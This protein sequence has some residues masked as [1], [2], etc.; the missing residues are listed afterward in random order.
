VSLEADGRPLAGRSTQ[1]RRLALLTLLAVARERGMTRDKVLAFLWP[2]RDPESAR[3]SLSQTLYAIH[4]ELGHEA[5][6]V[7][8][9]DLRL[10]ASVVT[11]DVG[12]FEEALAA[13]RRED[14][15]RVYGGAFLDG[16]FVSDAPEFERWA[17]CERQRLAAAYRAALAALAEEAGSRGEHVRAVAWWRK[18]AALEP[19]NSHIAVRLM[20]ALARTG[21]RAGAIQHAGA[22]AA[23]L[24][25]ELDAGADPDV[26][27]LAD[28]MRAELTAEP[29]RLPTHRPDVAPAPAATSASLAEP[30]APTLPDPQ[31]PPVPPPRR[32]SVAGVAVTLAAA[33]FAAVITSARSHEP[34][35]RVARPVVLGTMASPDPTLGLA[36]RE[37][38]WA[39]LESSGDIRVVAE[40]GM[41]E[42][43]RYMK[44]PL[45]TLVDA[46]IALEIAQRR[47]V[48]I[49][50]AGSIR[51]LGTGMQT[52]VKLFHSATGQLRAI[53]SERAES[54]AEVLGAV[55]RL[56]RKVHAEVTDT[57]ADSVSPLPGVT[58]ASLAA[59]RNYARAREALTQLDRQGAITLL[60]AAIAH[61]S[62]FAL[63]HY[64]VGDLLWY[65]D[66]QSHSDAHLAT[67]LRLS[68]RLPP[69]ERLVVRA[70]YQ[71][72]VADR[73][74]SALFYWQVLAKSYPDEPLAYDG[75]RWVYRA[76]GE[77]ALAAAASESA[78]VRDSTFFRTYVSDRIFA[79]VTAGD[80]AGAMEFARSVRD[81]LP[82]AEVD[83]RY[84]WAFFRQD[85]EAALAAAG[86]PYLRHMLLVVLGRLAEAR[87]ELEYL[88]G[89]PAQN[90]P[91]ALILQGRAELGFEGSPGRARDLAREAMA[92]LERADLSP[93][94]YARLAERIADLAARA[95]DLATVQRARRLVLRKDA[96]RDFRS[97]RYARLMID[98]CEAYARNAMELA[99][100][101]A[102]EA[103]RE[104]FYGRSLA[105]VVMLE[106]DARAALGQYVQADSLYRFIV[107]TPVFD[108]DH[109]THALLRRLART[110]LDHGAIRAARLDPVEALRY[111]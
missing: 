69:R 13:G 82:H 59:L 60:E 10:N 71:Q 96:G 11:T 79:L 22:L 105:T 68:D 74:D 6:L 21:D 42:T 23:L 56:A 47:G 43:L 7:G 35:L 72:L 87:A 31:A 90:T 32:R 66:Q 61:D 91:R 102:R 29:S 48:P 58:T 94:A 33:A 63:A 34:T 5:V 40:A 50:I 77:L 9:D 4:R 18:R 110:A 99:A 1:R 84:G 80:S 17:E 3:H 41:R 97:Y 103:R 62:L 36:V 19:L 25:N 53:V 49:V 37:A 86:T 109:E 95:G 107:G 38:L 28:R 70:R 15:V 104:M 108:G 73:P 8:A 54:D 88:R 65:V 2:E 57:R 26:T 24:R 55:M 39:E 83:A 30:G 45:D 81:R 14:A 75:M 78:A 52:V 20:S 76:L 67:A 89:A 93:P 106:A 101:L 44:L 12:E 64:L 85:F 51:P 100:R 46:E 92:W 16:F 111:E 27:A 98:A